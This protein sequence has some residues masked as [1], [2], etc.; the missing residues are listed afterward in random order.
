MIGELTGLE[1]RTV[2]VA[3]ARRWW[4][5]YRDRACRRGKPA[6]PWR[7]STSTRRDSRSPNAKRSRPSAAPADRGWST[8]AAPRGCTKRSAR[9]PS[10]GRCTGSC[11]SRR[12]LDKWA[13]IVTTS[14]EAWDDVVRLNLQSAFLTT[15][16]VAGRCSR[17]ERPA[18]SCTSRRCRGSRDAVRRVVRRGEGRDDRAHAHRGARARETAGIRVNT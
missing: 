5:R 6:P 15:R 17:R 9:S 11:T 7:H 2:I 3:G 16:T 12:V 4:D 14:T 10:S 1:G 18:A 8:C 13:P